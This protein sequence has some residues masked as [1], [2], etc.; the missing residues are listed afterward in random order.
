MVQSVGSGVRSFVRMQSSSWL[1]LPSSE[2]LGLQVLILKWF[3]PTARKL[4]VVGRW[5]LQHGSWLP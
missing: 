4:L 3:T 2:G 1:L 5:P